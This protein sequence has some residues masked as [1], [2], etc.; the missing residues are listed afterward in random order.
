MG[1]GYDDLKDIAPK[2]I[3]CSI[4]G[5]GIDGPYSNRAGYDV[6]AA[7]IGRCFLVQTEVTFELVIVVIQGVFFTSLARTM[8]LRAK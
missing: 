3:Y 8:A 1:L 5:F 6:I 2:L 4:T 7:S